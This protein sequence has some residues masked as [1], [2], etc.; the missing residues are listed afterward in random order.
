MLVPKKIDSANFNAFLKMQTEIVSKNYTSNII[1][2]SSN[3]GSKLRNIVI[4][5]LWVK[6]IK[7][8]ETGAHKCNIE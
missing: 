5:L 2:T 8:K 1:I 4:P 6:R 3:T 7:C